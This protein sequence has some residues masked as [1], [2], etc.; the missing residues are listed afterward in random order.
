LAFDRR[1]EPAQLNKDRVQQQNRELSNIF[2]PSDLIAA[3][4]APFF[5]VG[6]MVGQV[7]VALGV[8]LSE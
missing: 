1:L 4:R 8:H 5:V 7:G 6:Q 2:L 3:Y